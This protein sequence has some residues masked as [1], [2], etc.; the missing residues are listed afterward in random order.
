MQAMCPLACNPE[1]FRYSTNCA[2]WD[3]PNCSDEACAVWAAA[4]DCINNPEYMMVMCPVACDGYLN[5][6]TG[7]L[8]NC[9][10]N[11]KFPVCSD[12][13]CLTYATYGYCELPEEE[14]WRQYMDDQCPATCDEW[15]KGNDRL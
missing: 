1:P 15:L 7:Q 2:G 9:R 14:E 5:E 6:S 13:A 8:N 11:I 10:G 3:D 12:E 4:G